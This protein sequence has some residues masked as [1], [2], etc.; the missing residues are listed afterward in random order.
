MSRKSHRRAAEPMLARRKGGGDRDSSIPRAASGLAI[1]FDGEANVPRNRRRHDQRALISFVHR[2]LAANILSQ[3]LGSDT[4]P[5]LEFHQIVMGAWP[6]W[7]SSR[8]I[9]SLR[10]WNFGEGQADGISARDTYL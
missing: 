4:W 1:P 7:K 9:F 10:S 3:G 6:P 8:S 5:G 2:A